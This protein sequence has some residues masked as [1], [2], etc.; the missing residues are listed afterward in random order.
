MH[1]TPQ[2][3]STPEKGPKRSAAPSAPVPALPPVIVFTDAQAQGDALTLARTLPR[4]VALCLRDYGL[5]G[6]AALARQLGAV[7]RSRGLAFM[8]AGDV[9]L[10]IGAGAQGVHLPE[11]V[12]R[13]S[14]LPL[15]MAH[16]H[17]LAVTMA[18]HSAGAAAAAARMAGCGLA[19]ILISPVFETASHPG[20]R[21]LG[22]MGFRRI[23][24]VPAEMGRPLPAYALG[25]ITPA[26]CARL[27]PAR[28]AGVAGIRFR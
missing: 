12:A 15:V 19:G 7:C 5:P 18:V 16:R 14:R 26:S 11:A 1:S 6:R 24:G 27:G 22:V 4:G 3:R 25:G 17:G 28:P 20:A 2:T 13:S 9:R 23:A 10:A 21:P 8:V